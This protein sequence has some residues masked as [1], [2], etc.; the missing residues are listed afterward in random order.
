MTTMRDSAMPP[1]LLLSVAVLICLASML[2]GCQGRLRL[3]ILNNSGE[4]AEVLVDGKS[5]TLLDGQSKKCKSPASGKIIVAWK[6][7]NMTF[8]F[9]FASRPHSLNEYIDGDAMQ[10]RVYLDLHKRLIVLP[11]DAPYPEG[12]ER[13]PPQ[14]IV[15]EGVVE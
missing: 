6:E 4:V 13:V 3:M 9:P 7:V 5:N 12:E 11:A 1:V 8:A 2:C 10:V 14:A 15:L